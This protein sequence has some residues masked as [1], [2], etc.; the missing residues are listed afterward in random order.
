MPH[1][2]MYSN[3]A[4]LAEPGAVHLLEAPLV[5]DAA[6]VR[7]TPAVGVPAK[8]ATERLTEAVEVHVPCSHSHHLH[9]DVNVRDKDRLKFKHTLHGPIQTIYKGG[10]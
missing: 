1:V 10:A 2:E 4:A 3:D 9:T 8:Q 6:V 7:Q 5:L